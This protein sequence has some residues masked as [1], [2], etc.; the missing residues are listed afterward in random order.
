MKWD[1]VQKDESDSDEEGKKENKMDIEIT[2]KKPQ[3]DS[4]SQKNY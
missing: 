4:K 2:S 3:I 1:V